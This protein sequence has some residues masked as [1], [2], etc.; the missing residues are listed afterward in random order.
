MSAHILFNLLNEVR[1]RDK[2]LCLPSILSLFCN[3]FNKFNST[4]AQMLDS[5]YHIKI[6]LKLIKTCIL[7]VKKSRFCDLSATLLWTS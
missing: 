2:M 5:I 3:D 4:G 7:G 6:K 1:K